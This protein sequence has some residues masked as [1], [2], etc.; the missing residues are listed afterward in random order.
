MFGP[1]RVFRGRSLKRIKR[2]AAGENPVNAT[3]MPVTQPVD[4]TINTENEMKTLPKK[5]IANSNAPRTHLL[6]MS[7]QVHEDLH[8]IVTDFVAKY[9]ARHQAKKVGAR[10]LDELTRVF[11]VKN[12][13]SSVIKI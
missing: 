4:S 13:V 10:D 12:A 11:R 6:V 1:R 2:V 9:Q 3:Q 5:K 8:A 7:K